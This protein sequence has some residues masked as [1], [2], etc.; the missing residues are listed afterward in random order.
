M[1]TFVE[2]ELKAL[3]EYYID[4]GVSRLA[5]FALANKELEWV[6]DKMLEDGELAQGE[7]YGHKDWLVV[8]K[9]MPRT[10]AELR[11][12]RGGFEGTE[13]DEATSIEEACT[14]ENPCL[15]VDG[16]SRCKTFPSGSGG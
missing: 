3:V 12:P 8:E 11:N 9:F 16:C 10:A 7:A 14:P 4:K 15:D 6:I 5:L 2:K 1:F 13:V